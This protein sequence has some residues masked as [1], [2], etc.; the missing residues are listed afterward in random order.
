MTGIV[1]EHGFVGNIWIRQN[2]LEK[3]G[4][5]VGGHMHYHDHVSLVVKGA[6]SV[7]VD[8]LPSKDF[9]APTYIVIKKDRKHK[10][11][12]L[13]DETVFYCLYAMRD[14][15]GNV[16]DV[17]QDENVPHLIIPLPKY[18]QVVPDNYWK[19]NGFDNIHDN[20]R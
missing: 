7:Q 16:V 9:V 6:V 13:E 10:I 2:Y 20:Y 1:E 14:I 8:D 19:E 15:D 12:A 3:A 11:V 17:Y 5:V 18:T 4:D